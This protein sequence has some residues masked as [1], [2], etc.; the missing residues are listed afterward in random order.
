MAGQ[1]DSYTS[2]IDYR[3]ARSPINVDD[4]N[5]QKNFNDLF[6][7]A[8]QVIQG[9]LRY[10]GIGQFDPNVWNLLAASPGFTENVGNLNKLYAP[11]KVVIAP[12]LFISLVNNAG[13]LNADIAS[14]AAGVVKQADGFTTTGA[15]HVGDIAECITQS[16]LLNYGGA[17]LTIGQR[18]WLAGSGLIRTTPATAAGQLE[19]YL[20]I[21]ITTS[22]LL[23]NLGPAIQH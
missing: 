18:Y 10:C 19:Q 3:L 16:G 2:P 22:Q 17:I 13:V 15:A 8:Q 7:F 14:A 20:G 23:V 9:L 12:T 21:A 1:S 4:P 11:G 6:D 5:T